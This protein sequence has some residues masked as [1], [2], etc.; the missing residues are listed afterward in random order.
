MSSKILEGGL[1][2]WVIAIISLSSIASFDSRVTGVSSE[3]EASSAQR[4]LS[5]M[6]NLFGSMEDN[7]SLVVRFPAA[8]IVANLS[9]AG[10]VLSV[11]WGSGSTS[12]QLKGL[13]GRFMVPMSGAVSFTVAGGAL[14]ACQIG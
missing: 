8:P 2:F 14:E 10:Q 6:A 11:D 1:G 7:S 9:L 3:L 5:D 12:E 13:E 4:L